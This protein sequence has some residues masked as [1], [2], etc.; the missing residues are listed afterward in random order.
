MHRSSGTLWRLSYQVRCGIYLWH[1]SHTTDP[2][3]VVRLRPDTD[4]SDSSVKT[5][6]DIIDS[7]SST[8]ST[9]RQ[10]S[11][12]LHPQSTMSS[13]TRPISPPS[14]NFD[15]QAMSTP[16]A[17]SGSK[18]ALQPEGIPLPPTPTKSTHTKTPSLSNSIPISFHA[19][20]P[21]QSTPRYDHTS[22]TS[23]TSGVTPTRIPAGQPPLPS[24]DSVLYQSVVP[25]MRNLQLD[26]SF[27]STTPSVF[28]ESQMDIGS[29]TSRRSSQSSSRQGQL[30][31]NPRKREHIYSKVHK[32]SVQRQHLELQEHIK[33]D[34]YDIRLRQG[35]YS[36]LLALD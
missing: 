26:G 5:P 25:N 20:L 13:Q 28:S 14:F 22:F 33:R 2:L 29:Q 27:T 16:S 6:S 23:S 36:A 21:K 4:D 3:L 1:R 31:R 7:T 10:S 19:D 34:I 11:L 12:P 8:S 35:V 32:A 17:P 30:R 18:S 24:T 15:F 9:P